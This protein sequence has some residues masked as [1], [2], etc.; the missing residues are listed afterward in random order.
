MTEIKIREK[1]RE[2]VA[3]EELKRLPYSEVVYK[4]LPVIA[5]RIRIPKEGEY[6]IDFAKEFEEPPTFGC[7][8]FAKTVSIPDLVIELPPIPLK[9]LELKWNLYD[10]D[11]I[12]FDDLKPPTDFTIN[13]NT[14][15]ILNWI[16]SVKERL[17]IME[18]VI[19]KP[20]PQPELPSPPTLETLELPSFDLSTPDWETQVRNELR[21]KLGNWKF[22]V[23]EFEVDLNWI[24]DGLIDAIVAVCNLIR[25]FMVNG[26]DNHMDKIL[27]KV[28]EEL[29]KPAFEDLVEQINEDLIGEPAVYNKTYNEIVNTGSGI[30]GMVTTT[31]Y[32]VEMVLRDII[33]HINRNIYYPL[34]TLVT[35][36]EN[37]MNNIITQLLNDIK[38]HIID[39]LNEEFEKLNEYESGMRE[40][41]LLIRDYA[42]MNFDNIVDTAN[43]NLK[44]LKSNIETA[45]NIIKAN[46][47]MQFDNIYDILKSGLEYR[48][49]VPAITE[50]NESRAKIV[51]KEGEYMW[52]AIGKPKLKK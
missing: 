44:T 43:K 24:R 51:A 36:I 14:N 52:Y 33:S 47:E 38:T 19:L 32:S 30:N 7:I 27:K 25:T 16:D 29:V 13:Y 23:G 40:R 31:Y 34:V 49:N 12:R 8:G 37:L 6:I 5:G 4:M 17:K 42:K 15:K 28:K 41:I 48:A 20:L 39:K 1:A 2:E 22:K 50:V 11:I 10:F 26:I 21:R 46:M 45:T 9:D 3:F 18:Q 35:A